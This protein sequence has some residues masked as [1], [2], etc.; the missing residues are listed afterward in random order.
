MRKKHKITYS[1]SI[2]LILI[3]LILAACVPSTQNI[4]DDAPAMVITQIVT[5]I[6]IPTPLPTKPPP[7][8]TNTPNPTP[9]YSSGKWTPYMVPIYYPITGCSASR[10]RVGVDAHVAYSGELIGL[11][12]YKSLGFE[13]NLRYPPA[14]TLVRIVDGPYCDDN[15]IYWKVKIDI[16]WNEV[17]QGYYPEGDGS[18]YWLL[19]AEPPD[20]ETWDYHFSALDTIP[21]PLIKVGKGSLCR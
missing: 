18:S 15:V 11:Y 19:P 3:S 1:F 2:G 17:S 13:P 7:L 6:V 20:G 10:L 8:P 9:T 12:R 5:Q 16:S 14:G 21:V 4:Q